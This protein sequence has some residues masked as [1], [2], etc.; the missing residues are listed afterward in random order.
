M[1]CNVAIVK[2]SFLFADI[3]LPIL[4]YCQVECE[5]FRVSVIPTPLNE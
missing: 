5:R 2:E 1:V 4:R 3:T